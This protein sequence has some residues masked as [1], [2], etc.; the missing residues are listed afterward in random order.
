MARQEH[1]QAVYEVAD[2]FR[3]R[4]L[5]LETSLLWPD[6][7]AWTPDTIDALWDAF[8][9]HPDAGEDSFLEKWDK[10]LADQPLDVH[11]V[12]ADAI[13]FYY[14]FP[15]QIG[16]A[17]KL[18]AVQQV[19]NWKLADEGEPQDLPLLEEA[20]K[21]GI[22]HG[23]MYYAVGQPQQIAFYLRFA[24]R[25]LTEG[26]DPHDAEGCKLLADAVNAEV[27]G[28]RSARHVLLHLLFPELF[29]R[30]SSSNYKDLIVAAFK[31]DAGGAEDVDDAL[32][33]IRRALSDR[34]E[35]PNLDFY[36]DTDLYKQWNP[37]AKPTPSPPSAET[38]DPEPDRR[39]S[40]TAARSTIETIYPDERIRQTC[41][42][43]VADSIERAHAISPASWGVTLHPN[44]VGLNVLWAQACT[45]S[46]GD[47]YLVLD[48]D[49][50][51]PSLRQR[52]DAEMA[53]GERSGAAYPSMPAAYGAHLPVGKLDELLPLVRDPHLAFIERAARQVRT[54][55]HFYRS[56][57]PGVIAYLRDVLKRDIPDPDY[58][59]VGPFPPPEPDEPP[60]LDNLAAM[61]NLDTASLKELADLIE[62]KRQIVIERP[63]RLGQDLPG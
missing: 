8:M 5:A 7:R 37:K 44:Q 15:G 51:D 33:N 62:D 31:A 57:S 32:L 63:A 53:I 61:T 35:R 43:T 24:R 38:D 40:A 42:S 54:R 2:R 13:A 12:A 18:H 22:G 19:I 16:P 14:L 23:G 27:K 10:Q 34:L 48:Q 58:G 50:F 56:H 47:L 4:C 9:G 26:V 60:T 59:L 45:L 36:D 6:H 1:A 49:E 46:S 39:M 55:C 25:V 3:D 17:A 29:E 20:F 28:S 41:L 30:I 52:I 11:R 21:Y